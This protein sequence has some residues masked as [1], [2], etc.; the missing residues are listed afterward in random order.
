[1]RR[2]TKSTLFPYTTL[3]RSHRVQRVE[4]AHHPLPDLP[5]GD[6]AVEVL[7]QLSFQL[8]HQVLKLVHADRTLLAGFQEP[9]EQL[10]AVER[11]PPPVL[12]DDHERLFF[13]VLIGGEALAAFQALAPSSDGNAIGA[14][15]RV[16]DLVFIVAA[17]RALHLVRPPSR[18]VGPSTDM[19]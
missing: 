18:T 7:R 14:G 11:L 17:E 12:L 4:P 9:G 19:A 2:P 5:R 15:A 3:F 16:H 1:M 13:D 10:M 8:I 6:L